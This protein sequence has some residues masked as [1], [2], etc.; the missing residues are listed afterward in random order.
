MMLSRTALL[1]RS[2]V[3]PSADGA[4]PLSATFVVPAEHDASALPLLQLTATV[5]ATLV[6]EC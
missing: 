3:Q 1:P 5:G 6:L 2:L 4:L